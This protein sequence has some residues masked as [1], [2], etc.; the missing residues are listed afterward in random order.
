M[1]SI[2]EK[3]RIRMPVSAAVSVVL[4][5]V[6]FLTVENAV[7]YIPLVF[8]IPVATYALS[9]ERKNRKD[10]P[11]KLMN[12]SPT[13][14]GMMSSVI[15]SEGSLDSAVRYVSDNGPPIAKRMF[16][17]VARESDLR[18]SDV[19][20][21]LVAAVGNI[22]ND[23]SPF[24]RSMHMLISSSETSDIG[25]KKRMIG[26]AE[27]ITLAGLKEMGDVYSSSLNNPCMMIFGL[28]VM[29]P[30]ILM[31]VMPML[32]MGG[33]FSVTALNTGTI[34]FLTLVVIPAIV[35]LVIVSIINNNPFHEKKVSSDNT[36]AVLF[37]AAPMF[38]VLYLFTKD[39]AMS[40]MISMIAAG[41]LTFAVT[42]KN[43]SEE[44]VIQ[45]TETSLHHVFFELGNRLLSGNNFE[46]SMIDALG[47]RKESL[48]LSGKF[49]RCARLFRG[50]IVMSLRIT[51]KG[52]SEEIIDGYIRVYEASC[53][54]TRDSGRLSVSIGHQMQD[55][56]QAKR[57]I[58]NKLK[59]ITDMMT[60]T[61]IFFAPLIMGMSIVLL[62]PMASISGM[63]V[64]GNVMLILAVYLIELALLLSVLTSYLSNNGDL[65][66]VVNRFSIMMPAGLAVFA[67]FSGL[68]V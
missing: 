39:P 35:S 64:D 51:L 43:V 40:L 52:Y 32:S 61:S 1:A 14:V 29:I 54:D 41:I 59:S 19:K 17:K 22:H 15:L 34:G 66:S 57:N 56:M 48:R 50:D 13:V 63:V 24:K 5:A 2:S 45:R 27:N 16:K 38:L 8:I 25:E 62:K 7:L 18:M 31:S 36:F 4:S 42:F 30:M 12:E 6:L 47:T 49:G 11:R 21:G 10:D 58:R 46:D 26:D 3:M 33:M 37:S 68:N 9:V 53:K 44:R 55:R 28:G 65:N 20:E 60:G 23:A 67:L